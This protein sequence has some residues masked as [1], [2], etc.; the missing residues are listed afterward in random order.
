MTK[1]RKIQIA[2]ASFCFILLLIV[3][4]GIRW[5]KLGEPIVWREQFDSG[6]IRME[7]L[8]KRHPD[9]KFDNFYK[10]YYSTEVEHSRERSVF[11]FTSVRSDTVS[12]SLK[13]TL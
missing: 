7:E 6:I 2:L 13:N 4:Q 5:Y 8:K 12:V 10:Y 11:P 9:T 3:A 1:R